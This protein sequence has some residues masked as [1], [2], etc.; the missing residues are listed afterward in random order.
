[1]HILNLAKEGK[2][3]F[4]TGSAGEYS[5]FAPVCLLVPYMRLHPHLCLV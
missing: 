5:I 2:S 1:M 3:L 4:Y